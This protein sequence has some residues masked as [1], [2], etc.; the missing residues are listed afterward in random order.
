MPM[1]P[2]I[3][4][5]RRAGQGHVFAHWDSLSEPQRASLLSEAAEID[6]AEVEM[7]SE[8]LFRLVTSV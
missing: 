1:H 2:L 7:A 4:H 3:E 5:F 8:I 6:L